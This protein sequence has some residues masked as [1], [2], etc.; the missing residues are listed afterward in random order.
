MSCKRPCSRHSLKGAWSRQ[1]REGSGR[2][3][4]VVMDQQVRQATDEDVLVVRTEG[5]MMTMNLHRRKFL[6]PMNDNY[7]Q[8]QLGSHNPQWRTVV[9]SG[10]GWAHVLVRGNNLVEQRLSPDSKKQVGMSC[11]VSL[12]LGCLS[13]C[14]NGLKMC[15]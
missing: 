12:F 3:A 7:V 9:T 11:R 8:T 10:V 6:R 4:S 2:V 5:L 1:G 15:F 14:C 13:F